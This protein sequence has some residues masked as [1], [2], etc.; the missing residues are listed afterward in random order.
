VADT[1]ID[2]DPKEAQDIC[3]VLTI[4]Y[5]SGSPG[6]LRRDDSNFP[7]SAEPNNSEFGNSLAL[8]VYAKAVFIGE[9]AKTA[10]THRPQALPYRQFSAPTTS[11][12]S[13]RGS[14]K[15]KFLCLSVYLCTFGLRSGV[16]A[17]ELF[18]G[19]RLSILREQILPTAESS[20]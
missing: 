16:A 13:L 14:L 4:C 5:A 20:V 6:P 15:V 9:W 11:L 18:P 8:L 3:S 17:Q 7:L 12:F 1:N 10:E 2:T 19:L